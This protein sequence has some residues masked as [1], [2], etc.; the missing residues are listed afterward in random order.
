MLPTFGSRPAQHQ[1]AARTIRLA[2]L[3]SGMLM[4]LAGSSMSGAQESRARVTLLDVDGTI[5]PVMATYIGRGIERA[6]ERN[7][8]AVI[9]E[10]DTPGG[11]SSSTDD[12]INDILAS[13]VPVIVY[14]APEGARAASAGVYIAY[15]AHVAA[16]APVTNIG[17]A[18]PIQLGGNGNG[19]ETALDRKVINDAVA[20][21]RGLAELRGR[22]A[23]WAEQA[24][25]DASNVGASE[26]VDLNVVDFIATDIDDLLAQAD[27]MTVNVLG[28]DM[29]V[30]TAGAPVDERSM[31]FFERV[32]QVVVDPNIAFIFI[33]LG[34]L[35]LI[36]ELSSP[37]TLFPGI[38]G[39]IM[40]VTGFYALGTLNANWTGFILIAFAFILFVVEVFVISGGL[41]TAGGVVAFLFGS[42][43]LSNTRNDDVLQISRALIFTVTVLLGLFFFLLV[44]S[45]A[46]S[47]NR[48]VAIGESRLIGRIAEAR[49]GLN[50]DGMVYIN[51]E[52]W[53]ATLDSGKL[54]KGSRVR[55]TGIDL[56]TLHV[57]RVEGGD[58]PDSFRLDPDQNT[59]GE[60][61]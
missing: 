57:Q 38:A 40:L 28:V 19:E 49:T 33:S 53:Q 12:I 31:T 51:G 52:L 5:T 55:V 42:L 61:S 23:D 15:A 2:C 3:L 44:G 59:G 60:R 56:L 35:G 29:T 47:R 13:H 4:L 22:N 36:F 26:A 9:L 43:L 34:T 20:R 25:R 17:S 24:V 8:A 11:L 30:E 1:T 54:D 16:M 58:L 27:G 21:I 14:V 50:P 10:M 37:G 18:T 48:P 46:K 41:L 45:A 7:D 39:A 32:L 6:G